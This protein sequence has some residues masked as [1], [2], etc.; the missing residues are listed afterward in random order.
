VGIGR[1]RSYPCASGAEGTPGAL[2]AS[3]ESAP[4]DVPPRKTLR[5]Q[6]SRFAAKKDGVIKTERHRANTWRSFLAEFS[7]W[8]GRE[9]IDEFQRQD[10]D[11]F[12][13]RL[14]ST[15]KN[16]P[17]AKQTTGFSRWRNA[18]RNRRIHARN[19]VY[20]LLAMKSRLGV[21]EPVATRCDLRRVI[22]TS[23][24]AWR[25]TSKV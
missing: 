8:W 3:T 5:E 15:G 4:T 22:C 11:L 7:K 18:S 9:Y 16:L 20:V 10:F 24:A 14:A 2:E 6:V 12:P 25:H 17:N 23:Q 1:Q 13:K 19:Y 21:A